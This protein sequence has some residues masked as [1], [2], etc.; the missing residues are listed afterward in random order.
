MVGEEWLV[1]SSK[2]FPKRNR[3]ALGQVR[4]R[5]ERER[6]KV[7]LI[8]CIAIYTNGCMRNSTITPLSYMGI[9]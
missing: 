9:Q 5:G 3:K 7:P 2:Q 8:S 1:K 4:E 6:E